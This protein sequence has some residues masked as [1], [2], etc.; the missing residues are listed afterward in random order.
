MA[1]A[2]RAGVLGL[3]YQHRSFWIEACRLFT[4]S[5]LVRRVALEKAEIRAFDDVVASYGRSIYDAHNRS[6]DADHLQAKF[7]VSYDREIR[8][9]DL[10]EP[11][12]INAR[13]KSLLDRVADATRT[14]EIPRRLT[15]ISPHTINNSDPLR[16]LVSP[17]SGEFNLGPLFADD[18]SVAMRTMRESWRSSLGGISDDRLRLI[19][20][21][22]RIQANVSQLDLDSKLEWRLEMAGLELVDLT[23]LVHRYEALAKS[24]ITGRTLEH[25][26]EGLEKILRQ[27]KLWIGRPV[28][29][30]DQPKPIGIKSFSPYSYELED[31]AT[32][33]NLLPH[34]HGREKIADVGWDRDLY[35]RVRAFLAE[36]V[37]SG[38][39]Y[40]LHLDTH[41]SVAFCAG[42]TL[43]KADAPVT[44]IQRFP[45]GGRVAWP[46]TGAT[47]AGPLWEAPR[48]IEIGSGPEV[49]LGIEVTQP[50]ADDVAIYAKREV[51][52]VGKLLVMTISGGPSRTS[53]RDGAHAHAL[54]ASLGAIVHGGRSAATRAHPLHIFGALPGA[55]M[56][57]IGRCSAPWG[58]TVTYEYEFD[59]RSPGA[60][61]PAFHLP[62]DTPEEPS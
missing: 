31:E 2:V 43:D 30:P 35:P 48:M 13:S 59:R 40:D 8:G 51:P 58:P 12:F 24:F 17:R 22:L 18:A 38:G 21:H 29:N 39:R 28:A 25:D 49:A 3:D 19:L 15:L 5:Q 1:G 52:A 56:F 26:R 57:L 10:A 42:Y 62:P 23:S 20:R 44:P 36:Q 45:N 54:A 16:M 46:A 27:E 60:Y 33:L 14:G 47:V 34:F 4:E 11:R 7:H 9:A 55:L 37:R 50:V 61:A 53:V 41:L 6:I 32:V